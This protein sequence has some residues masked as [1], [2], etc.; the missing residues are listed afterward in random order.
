MTWTSRSA[1]TYK[2]RA[3]DDM[4]VVEE[5]NTATMTARNGQE[6]TEQGFDLLV[7]SHSTELGGA[8]K[9]WRFQLKESGLDVKYPIAP[10][11]NLSLRKPASRVVFSPAQYP[12]RR[13]SQL[14]I[15]DLAG[16]A[17]IYDL[18]ASKGRRRMTE[19][20]AEM[21]AFVA[22]FRSPFESVKSTTHTPAILAGRKSII[23]ATW[24]SDG[25]HALILLT[26]GEWG[27]WDVNRSGPSPP[28][29]P[30]T[31][32]L[33]AFVGTA[34]KEG[35]GNIAT[36]P[37][38]ASRS[39]LAPMTPNTRRRKEETLFQGSSSSSTVA[40]RGGISVASRSTATGAAPEDSV[41]IWYGSEIHRISDLAKFWTRTAAAAGGNSLPGP[42]LSQ[43]Q[44]IS[45]HGETIT[46]ITQFDT[47]A[48]AARL[49]RPRD[50][51]ISAEHRLLINTTT[52]HALGRD[53]TSM[54]ANEEPET[55]ESKRSDQA[56]L[57][58]GELDLGGMDRL[59][60]DMEG[61]A[62]V[63][64]SLTLGNPRRVLFASS[65]A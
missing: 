60:D 21:G 13:H 9:I 15:A 41:I 51:L 22:T 29:D 61:S 57:S 24:A 43:I 63:S 35:S 27:I 28:E 46:S 40:P 45:L 38:R 31:F 34:E 39:S 52:T 2:V 54:F 19:E 65:A 20:H 55:E 17:R 16:T 62:T 42:G 44:D 11:R 58:H 1:P 10:Y 64:K 25:H 23:D 47:T 6:K 33:R 12:K 30:S 50:L 8:L 49:A 26:D 59:L 37:K 5:D 56:L 4:D 48:E 32:S 53:L 18:F 7:A 3:E 36:S 14:L